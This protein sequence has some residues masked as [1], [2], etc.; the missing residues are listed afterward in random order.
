M[1]RR[2][3]LG[4]VLLVLVAISL[5]FA[6]PV[7]AAEKAQP[8]QPEKAAVKAAVKAEK[9]TLMGTV[10]ALGKDKKGVVTSVGIQTDKGDYMVSKKGKGK[11][12]IKMVDKKVE[13][14]GAVM[15]KKGKKTISVSQYKVI[16]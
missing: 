14:T 9:M 8:A 4:I 1:E 13:V 10:K 16:E 2:S 15:E 3:R 7:M 11:D 5:I 12:L 6:G